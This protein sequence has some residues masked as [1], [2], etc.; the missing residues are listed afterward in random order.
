MFRLIWFGRKVNEGIFRIIPWRIEHVLVLG[1]ACI[2]LFSVSWSCYVVNLVLDIYRHCQKTIFLMFLICSLA[3]CQPLYQISF[4]SVIC[5]CYFISIFLVPEGSW[6]SHLIMCW[7][8]CILL[9]ISKTNIRMFSRVFNFE[10]NSF[11]E[12]LKYSTVTL[13]NL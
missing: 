1:F 2:F 3:G 6:A 4:Q 5:T 13:N 8:A 11:W 9:I 7:A 10:N 12:K